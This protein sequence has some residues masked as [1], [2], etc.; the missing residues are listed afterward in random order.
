MAR[1]RSTA[2]DVSNDVFA[3]R[4]VSIMEARNMT[5]L[6]LVDTITANGGTIQRQTISQYMA[7]V[8]KPDTERLTMLCKALNVS[9][10]YL[11]GLSNLEIPSADLG[12]FSG[13]TGLSAQCADMLLLSNDSGLNA[14][15]ELKSAPAFFELVSQ[16]MEAKEDAEGFLKRYNKS[17]V[18]ENISE[19]SKAKETLEYTFFRAN[20]LARIMLG[21]NLGVYAVRDALNEYIMKAVATELKEGAS[22]G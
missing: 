9:A 20:D 12:A 13:F 11:L 15:M 3:S 19:V 6:K 7:G 8:S 18:F 4:L 2:N 5:Q 22:H 21:N 1:K 17:G 16:L 10:D 14:F